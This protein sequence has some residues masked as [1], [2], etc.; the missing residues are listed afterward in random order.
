MVHEGLG[1]WYFHAGFYSF[2]SRSTDANPGFFWT[3]G[4]MG[5]CWSLENGHATLPS[6][7]QCGSST[8][9]LAR[10]WH[11]SSKCPIQR[12]SD[13]IWSR[14]FAH[15]GFYKTMCF[16]VVLHPNASI[17]FID[18]KSWLTP[19]W[20]FGLT[21]DDIRASLALTPWKVIAIG[22]WFVAAFSLDT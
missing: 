15:G 19:P 18:S 8:R 13:D 9:S 4:S 21:V 2:E 1:K 12:L 17:G 22:V 6:D 3:G 7:G 14:L 5:W 20:F 11:D 16:T 10:P